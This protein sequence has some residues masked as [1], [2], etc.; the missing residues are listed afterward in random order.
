MSSP[1]S[2]SPSEKNNKGGAGGKRTQPKPEEHPRFAEWYAAYPLRKERAAAVAAFNKAAAKV[3]DIEVLFTAAKRYREEDPH[4][5]R[6][7]IKNPATWLNKEC[8]LDEIPTPQQA[9]PANGS[10]GNGSGSQMPPRDAD[11]SDPFRRKKSA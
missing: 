1:T 10:A 2:S 9:Q 6:G 5:L 7:F 8:W 3:D 4:V 11:Y